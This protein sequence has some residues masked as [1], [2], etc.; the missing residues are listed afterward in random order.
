ME[1]PSHRRFEIRFR[2][3]ATRPALQ[4]RTFTP[5]IGTGDLLRYNAGEPR[6][7]CLLQLSGL[8]DLTGDGKPD[9]VG[10]WNYAHRPGRPYDGAACHPRVGDAEALHFGDMLRL[11]YV[12]S[13]D[14]E[15]Y[16]FLSTCLLYTSPSPRD[17]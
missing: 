4:P 10:C 11:R 1:D 13:E 8:H 16:H 6:P 14:S 7:I 12:D 5:L 9:L 17:S 2:T 15:D 3:V